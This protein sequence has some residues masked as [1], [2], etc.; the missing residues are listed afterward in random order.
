MGEIVMYASSKSSV[1]PTAAV[2]REGIGFVIG[3][4]MVKRLHFKLDVL[5]T[6]ARFFK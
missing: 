2:T 5:Q 6:W 4:R 3:V 1:S